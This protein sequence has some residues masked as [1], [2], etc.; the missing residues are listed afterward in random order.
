MSISADPSSTQLNKI[1]FD[2]E[3][4]Q[5]AYNAVN[6][7]LRIQPTEQVCVI[8][9]DVTKEIAAAIVAEIE[10]VGAP[11]RAWVL[12]EMATRPLKDLPREILDDLEQSQVSILP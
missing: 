12:E 8:T 4:K 2:P 7:C 6:V 10:K 5:G 1:S 3:Y 9:D 11:Y